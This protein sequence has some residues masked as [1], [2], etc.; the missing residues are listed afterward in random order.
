METQDDGTR[1]PF[2]E[3][4]LFVPY[5]SKMDIEEFNCI[6][7]KLTDK[8]NQGAYI[9]CDTNDQEIILYEEDSNIHDLGK[10]DIKKVEEYWSLLKKG[11]HGR[12]D[13]KYVF[14]GLTIPCNVMGR[15]ARSLQGEIF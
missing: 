13:I 14:E 12:R 4:S 6:A 8:Y 3:L 9:L 11:S 10:F 1:V 7:K 2:K 5:N 15:Y